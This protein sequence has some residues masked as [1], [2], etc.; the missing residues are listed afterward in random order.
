MSITTGCR[1]ND[2][3]RITRWIDTTNYYNIVLEFYLTCQ[4]LS[5][6]NDFAVQWAEDNQ[7]TYTNLETFTSWSWDVN[8][9]KQFSYNLPSGAD[10]NPILG[11][12]FDTDG[13]A[14]CW[15][16]EVTLS[17]DTKSPTKSPTPSPTSNPTKKPT[18]VPSKSPSKAP[19]K[20]PSKYPTLFPSESPSVSPSNVP[21]IMPTNVP[22]D[23]PTNMPSSYPSISPSQN[24]TTP[25]PTLNPTILPTVF[26]SN[27]PTYHPTLNPSISP[28]PKPTKAPQPSL[29]IPNNGVPTA[30]PSGNMSIHIYIHDASVFFF[31][32]ETTRYYNDVYAK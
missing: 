25:Q 11:I 26:P 19:S 14:T 23:I 4:G 13:T 20:P 27:N 12:R 6:V 5:N 18:D 15:V 3:V 28:T 7:G 32:H 29:T 9:N 8:G 30:A 17:G 24:P 2:D 10:N 31:V 21:T 16:D 22:T 1:L